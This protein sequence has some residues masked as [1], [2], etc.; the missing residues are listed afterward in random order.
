MSP[1]GGGGA[2]SGWA[3][4]WECRA[5]QSRQARAEEAQGASWGTA[6]GGGLCHVARRRSAGCSSGGVCR[7]QGRRGAAP[8]RPGAWPA[9]TQSAR[10]RRRASRRG[11]L[12][13]ARP[14]WPGRALG[15]KACMV[16]VRI[17]VRVRAWRRLAHRLRSTLLRGR[18]GRG[19]REMV[20]VSPRFVPLENTLGPRQRVD[21][22]DRRS[23]HTTRHGDPHAA[24]LQRLT[25]I[26]H[27]H[28]TDGDSRIHCTLGK[29]RHAGARRRGTRQLYWCGL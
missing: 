10:G 25:F 27:I 23:P 1:R 3:S 20:L 5:A 4:L 9:P 17:R 18:L 28:H 2:P 13:L 12:A 15:V 6:K 7:R 22:R 11:T 24:A 16:R 8:V 19:R 14:T 29:V 21:G 26:V